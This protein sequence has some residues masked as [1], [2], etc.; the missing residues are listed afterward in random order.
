MGHRGFL[1]LA[2]GYF[3]CGYQVMFLGTHL[4]NFLTEQDKT[5]G[6]CDGAVPDRTVQYFRHPGL[7]RNGRQMADEI[8]ADIDIPVALL[9]L[10]VFI[11]LQS[12]RRALHLRVRHRPAMAGH[13]A[14][15][16]RP[17]SP[18]IACDTWPR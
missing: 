17:G 1:L 5:L 3:V 7:G 18:D 13:R 16:I 8:S 9:V 2:A 10:A 6:R 4:P 12:H 11:L 14:A 15:D